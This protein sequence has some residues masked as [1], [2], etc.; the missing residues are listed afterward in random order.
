LFTR[1]KE[2]V[3]SLQHEHLT[4]ISLRDVAV[5]WVVDDMFAV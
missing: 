2:Q 3:F 5:S 1:I 4:Y